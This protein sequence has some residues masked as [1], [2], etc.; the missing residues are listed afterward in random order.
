MKTSSF[1]ALI[2][3]LPTLLIS[4]GGGDGSDASTSTLVSIEVVPSDPMV[5]VGATQQFAATGIYS[6][7]TSRGLTTQVT[8]TSSNTSI[9]TVDGSGLATGVAIGSATISATLG[10]ISDSAS[11]MVTPANT[12]TFQVGSA[13]EGIAIDASGNVWIANWGD[14]SVTK[15]SSSGAVLGT[16]SVDGYPGGIAIDAS[17]NVWVTNFGSVVELSPDGVVLGTFS[18]DG[19]KTTGIAIDASGNVWVTNQRSSSVTE[20]S[21]SG[22]V[23]GT[24]PTGGS[25]TGI[26]IDASGNVWIAN[27]DGTVTKL[28]PSGAVLGTFPSGD[29]ATGIAI[30]ASGNVWVTNFGSGSVTKLSS[31]GAVLGT[32]SVGGAPIG[33]AIDASGNVWVTDTISDN[34]VC[35]PSSQSDL[36]CLD[37][38]T[39]LSPDGT[40]LGTFITGGVPPLQGGINPNG[41]AIDTAGNVWIT[42]NQGN[43]VTML[44]QAA[45]GPQFWP[46][47]GPVWPGSF[48]E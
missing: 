36:P 44:K 37:G 28:G 18:T 12:A 15:L 41:I 33:I 9:V 7:G 19:I 29:G 17:G 8:W 30:D 32:F 22:T 20:L 31:G 25:P 1:C 3:F 45:T 11:L 6:D 16:F 34:S 27:N 48:G 40:V 14:S 2:L 10:G 5:N 47:T 24:F 4:C 43:S 23:V 46:Y 13:P 39:E 35:T 38:I 26:A 42:N 21:A